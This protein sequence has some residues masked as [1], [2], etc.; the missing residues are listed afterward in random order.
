[1]C[2]QRLSEG[3]EGTFR[4]PQSGWKIV[5]QSRTGCQET[6][7]AKFVVCSSL[8][9]RNCVCRIRLYLLYGFKS[10]LRKYS[11]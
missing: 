8:S 2:F 11:C 4:P 7:V 10:D 5:P 9:C 6:P 3:I 1:M